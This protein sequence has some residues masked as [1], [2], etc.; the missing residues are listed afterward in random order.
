MYKTPAAKKSISSARGG[1]K[2]KKKLRDIDQNGND[3][4]L[5]KIMGKRNLYSGVGFHFHMHLVQ[6]SH[7]IPDILS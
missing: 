6:P 3:S 2:V 4:P 7:L 5:G 1:K